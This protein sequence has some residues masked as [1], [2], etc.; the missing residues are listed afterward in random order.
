GAANAP[1]NAAEVCR[2]R[3][4]ES[5]VCWMAIID[6]RDRDCVVGPCAL[7]PA[8][9]TVSSL[10]ESTRAKAHSLQT[11]LPRDFL[12]PK[13]YIG[14]LTPPQRDVGS[15]RR[16]PSVLL[17]GCFPGNRPRPCQSPHEPRPRPR[18]TRPWT[19]TRSA[20]V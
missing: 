3:R 8:R 15:A 1:A 14:G 19:W 18:S 11:A 5:G 2:K 10:A 16:S 12:R 20:S 13:P 6:T 9:R 4:R 17:I 7:Y